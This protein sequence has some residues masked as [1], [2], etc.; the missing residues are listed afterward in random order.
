MKGFKTSQE[1]VNGFSR[2]LD[3]LIKYNDE[4]SGSRILSVY[5]AWEKI[6]GNQKLALNSELADI[7]NGIAIIKVGHTGWSQQI[8]MYKKKIIR[9]FAEL[10]PM[11]KVKDISIVVESE[12][13]YYEKRKTEK[14]IPTQE[15][16]KEI[17]AFEKS[18]NA[19]KPY[20]KELEEALLRL[21]KSVLSKK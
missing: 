15:E 14:Y 16:I 6:I 4:N 2:V 20:P 21:K 5:D 18:R 3:S 7:K 9:Q 8:L 17:E 12:F 19:E 11:F 1:L 10:Y 13:P